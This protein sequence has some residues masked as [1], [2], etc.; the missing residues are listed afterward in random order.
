[1]NYNPPLKI[2][3]KNGFCVEEYSKKTEAGSY[4]KVYDDATGEKVAHF[5]TQAAL[6]RFT[7]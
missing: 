4:W 3:H 1:M 7:N 5:Y 2:T 6:D